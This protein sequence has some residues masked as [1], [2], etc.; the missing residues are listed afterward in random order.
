MID[1]TKKC[2]EIRSYF[3]CSN[4]QGVYFHEFVQLLNLKRLLDFDLRRHCFPLLV[5]LVS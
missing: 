4:L 5:D 3:R 1:S 2:E